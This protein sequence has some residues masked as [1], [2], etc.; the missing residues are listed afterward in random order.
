VDKIWVA[1][2]QILHTF[3]KSVKIK[4]ARAQIGGNLGGA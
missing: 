4:V 1:R 3:I 2:D